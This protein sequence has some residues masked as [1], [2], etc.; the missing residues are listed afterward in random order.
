VVRASEALNAKTV[1]PSCLLR[2]CLPATPL[3]ATTSVAFLAA[4]HVSGVLEIRCLL[5]N[6]LRF[7][8]Y[9][10][11]S[12]ANIQRNKTCL[13]QMF[14][15]YT[16]LLRRVLLSST[17]FQAY[18]KCKSFN[19]ASHHKPCC[20]DNRTPRT[21]HPASSYF[22]RKWCGFHTWN[23]PKECSSPTVA[24]TPCGFCFT[25]PSSVYPPL[26]TSTQLHKKIFP[27][28]TYQ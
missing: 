14:L 5:T 13:P 2:M 15:N 6:N 7:A 10:S 20:A 21:H 16:C 23:L 24:Q 12:V 9:P 27:L 1:A 17:T 19:S 4:H 18:A 11:H 3:P 22:I 25:H 28:S 26:N 8:C